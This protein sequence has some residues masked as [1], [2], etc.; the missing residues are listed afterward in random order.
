VLDNAELT[1]TQEQLARA[2]LEVVL[3]VGLPPYNIEA[4]ADAEEVGVGLA[5]V[6]GRRHALRVL[7][8]QDTTA[9]LHLSAELV[10]APQAAMHQALRTILSAHRFWVEDGSAGEAPVVLAASPPPDTLLPMPAWRQSPAPPA[11]PSAANAPPGEATSNSN[12]PSTSL[13][14][15]HFR[16]Q[17]HGPT[18]TE[19]AARG[20]TMWR[21]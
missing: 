10:H 17:S 2:V 18:T 1:E 5:P 16:N 15:P 3:L 9:A 8:R 11:P 20:S 12:V 14:S 4:A 19:S 6:P 21:L 7:W 13:R